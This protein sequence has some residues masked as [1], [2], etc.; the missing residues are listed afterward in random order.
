MSMTSGEIYFWQ[1]MTPLDITRIYGSTSG[2]FHS[3]R[4]RLPAGT[5]MVTT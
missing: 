1:K 2:L 5:R 4:E 3:L